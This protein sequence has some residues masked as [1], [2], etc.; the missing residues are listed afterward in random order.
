LT[1]VENVQTPL[2]I[3]HSEQDLRCPIEQAEQFFVALKRLKRESQLVRFPNSN[4]DLSRNG[5]PV[6]RTERLNRIVGWFNR[7][8]E[9]RPEDYA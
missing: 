1:Y 9:R 2:L 7:F 8:I 5:K 6:L 3:L 4:H